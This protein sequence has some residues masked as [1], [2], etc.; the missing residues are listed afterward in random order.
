MVET[1]KNL[2]GK[3]RKQNMIL[4]MIR[5]VMERGDYHQ[6]TYLLSGLICK[7]RRKKNQW[8]RE[9]ERERERGGGGG[10]KGEKERW[11]WRNGLRWKEKKK[12]RE[13]ERCEN[14]CTNVCKNDREAW[15]QL[16][17]RSITEA[18]SGGIALPTI[19]LYGLDQGRPVAI[20]SALG[21]ND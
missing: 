3:D 14:P 18:Q 9:G 17:N 5:Q 20:T 19:V 1:N 16:W 11:R 7:E 15:L 6:D 8:E 21:H 2:K 10:G 4:K 13:Q 12:K